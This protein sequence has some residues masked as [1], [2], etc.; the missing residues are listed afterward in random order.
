MFVGLEVTDEILKGKSDW[1]KLFEP[2]NFFQKYKYVWKLLSELE[3]IYLVVS[4]MS[5]N[6]GSK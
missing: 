6:L 1:P 3:I 2:L 5:F 4:M